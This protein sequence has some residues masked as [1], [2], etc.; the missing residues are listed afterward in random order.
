MRRDA[1]DSWLDRDII[2]ARLYG[3]PFDRVERNRRQRQER[4]TLPS[5]SRLRIVFFGTPG[6]AVPALRRLAE[7]PQFEIRLVVTQPDRPAG[8]GRKL[9]APPVKIEAERLGLPVYQPDSLRTEFARR[10]LANAGAD[11]FVVAAYGLIFGPKTLAIPT[12]GCL[13]LHASLLP[14]YRGA[15]PISAAILN[16]DRETG[17]TLMLMERGLDTGPMIAIAPVPIAPDDTTA[18]LTVRLSEAGAVLAAEA[19]LEFMDGN[20]KAVPQPTTGASEVRPLTK[21]DGQLDWSRSAA[22]LERTVRAM[23]PWPRAWSSLGGTTIQIHK[24]RVIESPGSEPGA[25]TVR[26]N[27]LIVACGEAS[28]RLDLVQLP[29]GKPVP[30]R[31]LA[32]S[33]RLADGARFESSVGANDRPPIIRVLS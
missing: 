11:A 31:Q 32:E 3:P 26:A 16:G 14:A 4:P 33:L 30:G 20:L 15:S 21:A 12:L 24:A 22:G 27:K 9:T 29:G 10:P 13:N 17:V 23:W 8:R 28:L 19:I 18:S 7:S 6:Y 2:T 5:S 1:F 25:I